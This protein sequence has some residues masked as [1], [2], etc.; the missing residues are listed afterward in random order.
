MKQPYFI[1][2]NPR[3]GS[4][5]LR[6]LLNHHPNTVFPPECGF[7]QWLYPQ[8]QN[9]D[10]DMIPQFIKDLSQT[11]K[12]EGWNLSLSGL[13]TYLY[14]A[15]PKTYQEVCYYVYKY[16]GITQ[17]KQVQVWGDKNNYY[18]DFLSEIQKIFPN[19]NYIHLT[20]NP[21]DICVSYLNLQ[22]VEK[23]VKYRPNVPTS[24]EEIAKSIKSNEQKVYTFLEKIDPIKVHTLTYENLLSNPEQEL[25]KVGNFLGLDLKSNLTSFNKKVYFDEPDFTLKW[26]HKTQGA[27]DS[28]NINLYKSHP[29]VGEINKYFTN[30]D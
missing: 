8:Y 5:L 10:L 14:D 2:A 12:F 17:G 15:K 3:S 23:G 20:R 16:Y 29:K 26:K 21:K 13:S 1:I 6:I 4:S 30:E 9:W 11:K 24:V 22:K 7:I 19:A 25:S 27:I 18:I 28:N